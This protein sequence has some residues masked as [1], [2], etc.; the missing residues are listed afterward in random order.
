MAQRGRQA[1]LWSASS[2]RSHFGYRGLW[3]LPKSQGHPPKLEPVARGSRKLSRQE[4]GQTP[5]AS[6]PAG[7][8]LHTEAE[9]LLRG[10]WS[11][12]PSGARVR[13]LPGTPFA[14]SPE[15]SAW[16]A[17]DERGCRAE[18]C[19][20]RVTAPGQ[21]PPPALGLAV[22]LRWGSHLLPV[23]QGKQVGPALRDVDAFVH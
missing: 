10:P 5:M 6:P 2:A 17:G 14:H 18:G 11:S 21:A 7:S 12:L 1:D 19:A 15:V 20:P 8:R 3:Q 13:P 4:H 9:K 16:G 22:Q 23:S